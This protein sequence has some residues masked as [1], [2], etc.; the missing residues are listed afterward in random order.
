MSQDPS[1]IIFQT[2]KEERGW[3]KERKEEKKKGGE[4]KRERT[5]SAI[6]KVF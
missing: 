1:K 5:F 3:E 2:E 4:R 6:V